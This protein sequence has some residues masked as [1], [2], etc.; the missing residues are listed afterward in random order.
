MLIGWMMTTK[1]VSDNSA[2]GILLPFL[3]LFFSLEVS[4]EA[5]FYTSKSFLEKFKSFFKNVKEFLVIRQGE[6]AK[7]PRRI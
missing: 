2:F 6:F 7:T 1:R 4:P 5:D 3:M